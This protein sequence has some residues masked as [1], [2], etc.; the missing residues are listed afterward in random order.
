MIKSLRLRLQLFHAIIL[1]AA[2][3]LFAVAFYRQ[4]H[5]STMSEIDAELLSGA[6]VLEGILRSVPPMAGEEFLRRLP[7]DLP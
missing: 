5:R 1:A 4:L 2:V 6:R 3:V 7:L